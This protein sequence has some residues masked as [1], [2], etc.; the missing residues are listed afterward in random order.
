MAE[1][2]G[3][4]TPDKDVTP[5]LVG[6]YLH[7]FFESPK[8]HA[9][10]IASHPEIISSTGKTKGQPKKPYTDA[11]GMINALR[12]DPQ[13][14]DLYKG[15]KEV[16]VT[17]KINGVDW[18]G[19][20]DC[21]RRNHALVIDLKTTQ[22]LHKT[23]WDEETRRRISFI[24]EYNYT[25]QM[26]IYQEL[27]FQRWGVRPTMVIAAVT[28]QTPP[29]KVAVAFGQAELDQAMDYLREHQDRIQQVRNGEVEPRRCEQ[30]AYCRATKQLEVVSTG[31]LIS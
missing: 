7:S 16:M 18:M 27:A 11:D 23:Y 6:N 31:D 30:C 19:K 21:I 28:K 15:R 25:L 5:L 20:L 14:R 3:T 12:N 10:F 17:G 29:D 8:A 4:W 26:A 1:L 2:N 22:D 24:E 9:A 13:F